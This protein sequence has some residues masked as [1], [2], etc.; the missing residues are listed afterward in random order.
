MASQQEIELKLALRHQ[1][2]HRVE[3]APLL[4]GARAAARTEQ[5]NS[6][7]FDTPTF[8]LR[9]RGISLRVRSDSKRHIQTIKAQNASGDLASRDEWETEL[10]GT[11][12]DFKAARGTALAPLLSK[13]LR[14]ALKPV[15]ETRVERRVFPLQAGDAAVELSLDQGRIETAH[16]VEA[17]CEVE[18]ELKDGDGAALF[19]LAHQLAEAAP[20]RLSVRSKAERGYGLIDGKGAQPVAARQVV[21]RPGSTAAS[22]FQTIAESCLYQVVANWE[23]VARSDPDGFHEMRVG[24]RRL[25]AAISIFAEMLDDR[26][27]ARIKKELK[28]L[29]DELAPARQLDVFAERAIE[30]LRAAH[31]RE[32]ALEALVEELGRRKAEV[33]ERARAAV[34]SDRFRDLLLDAAQWIRVGDWLTAGDELRQAIRERPVEDIAAQVLSRRCGKLVKRGAK[35]RELDARKRHKLRIAAKKLRYGSEFFA[36]LFKTRKARRRRRA[37]LQVLKGL[38]DGLGDLNDVAAHQALCTS[39]TRETPP[40]RQ[41]GK[42]EFAFMA[43]IACGREEARTEPLLR[44]ATHAH[45]GLSKA[46]PFWG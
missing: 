18:I 21:V 46:A 30:P 44:A 28:W 23:A 42:G 4:R 9:K 8:K 27:T 43:G 14:H 39:L 45:R 13:K 11:T 26:Q 2:L 3:N 12:P 22:A 10:A 35:L 34:G 7:Y 29:T 24:L 15:F 33:E 16:D 31:R 5:L 19:R 38:Q 17:I 6:V 25:R 1:D 36:N 20:L 40:L 41:D 32:P 37:F